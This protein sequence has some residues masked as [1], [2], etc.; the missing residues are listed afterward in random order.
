[1]IETPLSKFRSILLQKRDIDVYQAYSHF[2]VFRV[3]YKISEETSR[4]IAQIGT[5]WLPPQREKQ[6]SSHLC[7]V[8]LVG[9]STEAMSKQKHCRI[10][11]KERSQFLCWIILFC[12]MD[13]YFH[14][15]N[16][17]VI[18]SLLCVLV[19][20]EGN[21]VKAALHYYADDLPSPQVFGVELFLWRRKWLNA[22]RDLPSSAVQDLEECDN[23]FFLNIHK[24]LRFFMYV[25]NY[26]SRM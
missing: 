20:R 17:A 22:D 25:A 24:L 14:P 8:L 16:D 18:S 5:A 1:M 19:C 9:N 2:K 4:N 21:P 12:E 3:R 7:H 26:I 15:N 10:I 6:T 23:G 13:T 11:T